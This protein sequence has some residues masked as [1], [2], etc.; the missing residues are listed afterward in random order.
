[1]SIELPAGFQVVQRVFLVDPNGV[2]M[3]LRTD[4]RIGTGISLS[5]GFCPPASGGGGDI[6]VW[7]G[8]T[9]PPDPYAAVGAEVA[10]SPG[11][12]GFALSF[13]AEEEGNGFIMY[14]GASEAP[15]WAMDREGAT[16]V[17]GFWNG[18][19]RFNHD[20]GLDSTK[21]IGIGFLLTTEGMR[22]YVATEDGTYSV[23]MDI[24]QANPVQSFFM[25]NSGSVTVLGYEWFTG[26]ISADTYPAENLVSQ[27][28]ADNS[29]A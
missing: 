13:A 17:P 10:I 9:R 24:D 2:E 7:T 22:I 11:L 5:S 3:L 27:W 14:L 1:M 15:G 19:T 16:I 26:T 6:E 28:V 20:S 18:T 23:L 12:V 4:M 25:S 8:G 29:G 21:I